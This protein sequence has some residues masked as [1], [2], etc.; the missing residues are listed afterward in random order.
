MPPRFVESEARHPVPPTFS[1]D[2]RRVAYTALQNGRSVVVLD[3]RAM[4]M[5]DVRVEQPRFSADSERLGCLVSRG[6]E[7]YWRVPR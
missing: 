3:D 6:R 5:D 2:G 1:P 7:I 4:E